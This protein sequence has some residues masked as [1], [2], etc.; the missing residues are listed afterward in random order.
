M[1]ALYISE[2]N[3]VYIG[4]TTMYD[5]N[6]RCFLNVRHLQSRSSIMYTKA[7]KPCI[8][9]SANFFIHISR[10]SAM[11]T[12][13]AIPYKPSSSANF[14]VYMKQKVSYVHQG[15]TTNTN[16]TTNLQMFSKA[17]NMR[18]SYLISS[19]IIIIAILVISI[20]ISIILVL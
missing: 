11:Y 10:S 8:T 3:Y 1:L 14:F 9:S 13:A 16:I 2:F 6:L 20:E 5:Q 4:S 19:I 7:L 15:S 12:K 17:V 18:D